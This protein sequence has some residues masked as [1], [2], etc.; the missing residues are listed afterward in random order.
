MAMVGSISEPWEM[1]RRTAG[2]NGP[3]KV[4]IGLLIPILVVAGLV[5]GFI[6]WKIPPS[7][8]RVR[9]EGEH[10]IRLPVSAMKIQCRGDAWH[11][12]LD[13]NAFTIFEMDRSDLPT[14]VGSLKVAKREVAVNK[15]PADPITVN[16][17]GEN[18][19]FRGNAE[20]FDKNWAAD[21]VP[22]E[23][24]SCD[25]PI[26]ADWL[27]VEFWEISTTRLLVKVHSD[28]N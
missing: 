5:A 15:T 4:L 8:L 17:L 18:D 1:E 21:L 19:Y 25:S 24:L 14:F 7:D 22:V 9:A 16:V 27:H 11:G 13:R 6:I 20:A 3:K 28:W 10:G 12:F 26:G 2:S 23:K